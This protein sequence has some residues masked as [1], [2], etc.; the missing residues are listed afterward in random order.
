MNTYRQNALA[1]GLLFVIADIAG[2]LAYPA[3]AFLFDRAPDYLATAAN[4][5][6]QVVIG[7]LLILTMELACSGIAVWLYPVLRQRHEALALWAVSLRTI[8]AICGIVAGVALLALIPLGRAFLAAGAPEAADFQ[9]LGAMILTTSDWTRDV[10]MLFAWG[11][12]AL[13][14]NLIF[15]RSRLLPRWLAGWGIL[16]ILLHLA[17]CLLTLFEV[18]GPSSPMQVALLAPSGLQELA[19]A[20]WLIVKGFDPAAVAR[21]SAREASPLAPRDLHQ[22]PALADTGQPQPRVA[23]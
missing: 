21:L 15:L 9:T 14:Y 7:V 13:L 20:V 6:S 16:A 12:G 17:A 8:E 4:H 5:S 3:L 10:V 2:P 1:A 23:I 11:L 22:G 19:L 18:I